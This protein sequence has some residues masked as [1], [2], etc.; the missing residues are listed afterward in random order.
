MRPT[1]DSVKETVALTPAQCSESGRCGR[2]QPLARQQ[3]RG[4]L[5][6]SNRSGLASPRWVFLA[7]GIRPEWVTRRLRALDTPDIRPAEQAQPSH[8]RRQL[9]ASRRQLRGRRSNRRSTTSSPA[10]QQASHPPAYRRYL[11]AASVV[12]FR[13][14]L[15]RKIWSCIL[16][17]A[18][19]AV[20][21]LGGVE[22]AVISP[23]SMANTGAPSFVTF[24]RTSR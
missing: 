8:G 5:R 20:F 1:P 17:A 24:A 15:A 4:H 6:E 16:G 21:A 23:R 9:L 7:R 10:V 3:H 22:P 19:I 18:A 13:R 12:G 11:T 14:T 2:G